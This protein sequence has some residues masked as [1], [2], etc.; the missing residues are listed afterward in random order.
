MLSRQVVEEIWGTEPSSKERAAY[1]KWV[2]RM[3]NDEDN[4]GDGGDDV[5]IP[6]SNNFPP[7]P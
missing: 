6:S 1:D 5:V 4:D 7:T 2:A 3:A